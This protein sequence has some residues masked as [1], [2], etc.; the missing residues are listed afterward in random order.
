MTGW[1]LYLGLGLLA[2]AAAAVLGIGLHWA[3]LE[4]DAAAARA[5]AT[6]AT[7]R[8]ETAERTAAQNAA[9]VEQQRAQHAL[10]MR[11]LADLATRAAEDAR[12]LSTELEAL[13]AE[14]THAAPAARVLE[15]AVD[16]LRSRRAAAGGPPS[17]DAGARTPVDPARPTAPAGAGGGAVAGADR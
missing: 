15:R 10:A 4:R 13:R 3:G 2:A 9:A 5:A 17:A 7:T 12:R 8:A 11:E 16:Q 6:A 14:P 1:R